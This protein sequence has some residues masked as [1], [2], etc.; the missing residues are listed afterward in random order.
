MWHGA[1][2]SIL[3]DTPHPQKKNLNGRKKRHIS[4]TGVNNQA[5]GLNSKTSKAHRCCDWIILLLNKKI[6]EKWYFS[7]SGFFQTAPATNKKIVCSKT[8]QSQS[9]LFNDKHVNTDDGFE[10]RLRFALH[11]MDKRQKAVW[12]LQWKLLSVWL[13]SKTVRVTWTEHARFGQYPSS[14]TFLLTAKKMSSSK[15]FILSLDWTY[16]MCFC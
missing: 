9:R 15:I 10:A 4:L 16:Q 13:A 3:F 8:C 6:Q 5:G 2:K 11:V 14:R 12:S 1:E 7:F